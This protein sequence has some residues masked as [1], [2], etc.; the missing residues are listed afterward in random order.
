MGSWL[1]GF[2]TD[3]FTYETTKSVVVKSW[4]VG[5]VNRIVQLL[6]ITYFVGSVVFVSVWFWGVFFFL[7]LYFLVLS[8]KQAVRKRLFLVV[9]HTKRE[10]KME[11]AAFLAGLQVFIRIF[12]D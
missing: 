10:V 7:F 5:I 3:F 2:V 6:I 4:S 11:T 9:F 1:W 8:E 12:K